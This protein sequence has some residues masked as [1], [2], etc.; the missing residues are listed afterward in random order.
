MEDKTHYLND[1]TEIRSLMERSSRFISLSGLSGVFAGIFALVGVGAAYY[2]LELGLY[3]NFYE[4]VLSD[5]ASFDHII[6]FIIIDA[7]LVLSAS[8]IVCVLLTTLKAKKKGMKIWDA[9]AQRLLVNLFIPLVAGGL[10]CIALFCYG[11]YGAIGL[12]APATM[13]FYGFALLNASKYTLNDIRYLGVIEIALGLIASFSI[14]YG[15]LLWTLGFGV[16]HIV[17]GS[18][19]YFKYERNK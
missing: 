7:F 4:D 8:L 11:C 15:L 16:M 9:T 5:S 12:I 1:I 19:M 13:I 17:Y 18:A 6:R 2:Y 3:Q 14:G 10:F